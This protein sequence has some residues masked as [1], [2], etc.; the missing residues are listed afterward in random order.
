M[1]TIAAP[2]DLDGNITVPAEGGL[3]PIPIREETSAAL[4]VA[5]NISGLSIRFFVR[6]RISKLLSL[7]PNNALGKLLTLTDAEALTLS[8]S[9]VTFQVIDETN[10]LV[11]ITI[12]SGKIRRA[13]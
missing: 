9:W 10:A 6:G 11:P 5:V 7:D 1:P 13:S 12:W 8:S 2:V 4:P 3:S